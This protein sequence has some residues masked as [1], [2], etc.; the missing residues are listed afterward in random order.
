VYLT[1]DGTVISIAAADPAQSS[2]S[3]TLTLTGPFTDAVAGDSGAQVDKAAGTMTFDRAGGVTHSARFARTGTVPITQNDG[4]GGASGGAG[5]S[6]GSGGARD[7]GL[8]SGGS[9]G[10]AA[11]NAAGSEGCGCTTAR[12]GAVGW[13]ALLVIALAPT[14][15]RRGRPRR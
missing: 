11:D 5:T 2:G 1:D 8:N 13:F 4:G 6:A 15:R 10:A 7:G 14:V 3:I 9:S 12:G